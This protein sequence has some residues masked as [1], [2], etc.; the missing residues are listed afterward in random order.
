[1]DEFL[2]EQFRK[3]TEVTPHI[4]LYLFDQ[5]SPRVD[6]TELRQKVDLHSKMIIQ[7]EKTCKE[8]R[9][10]VEYSTDKTNHLGDKHDKGLGVTSQEV[11]VKMTS[12][13]NRKKDG[14][15]SPEKIA[16]QGLR[17]EGGRG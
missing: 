8:L 13:E 16:R 10:R 1:M 6:V 7:M 3:H 14:Y 12:R 11:R 15:C 4:T 2:Q 5:R 17:R 9:S